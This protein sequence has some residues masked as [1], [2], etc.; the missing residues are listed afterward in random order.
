MTDIKYTRLVLGK[1]IELDSG[2]FVHIPTIK[3]MM[4]LKDR[5]FGNYSGP[6]TRSIRELFSYSAEVDQ[7]EEQFPSL[8][9]A[10]QDEQMDAACGPLF[11]APLLSTAF[12]QGFAY[13]MR[14]DVS[15]FDR[16]S[17][18]KFINKQLNL[19]IDQEF[20]N[21]FCHV[22]TACTVVE[23]DMDLIAPKDMSKTQRSLWDKLYKGRLRKLEKNQTEL[24]DKI[25]I[26]SV[27]SGGSFKFSDIENLTY[28]QFEC[29]LRAHLERE[30]TDR[31]FAIYT[32]YKFDTKD[33]KF[34]D[35]TEKVGLVKTT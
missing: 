30:V 4:D 29:L 5:E 22:I 26:L 18:G 3:E 15:E 23:K 9:E 27:A 21:D 16:M 24:G 28:Y 31:T 11:G 7:I 10:A 6:F 8:W 25:L 20:F 33:M 35:W 2:P 19:V 17:N 1:D 32:A 13:W 12:I 34:E 14:K